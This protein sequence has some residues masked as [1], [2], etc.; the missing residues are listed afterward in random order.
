VEEGRPRVIPVHGLG[1]N[2]GWSVA[3][4]VVVVMKWI[5]VRVGVGR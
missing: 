1:L 5:E 3:R 2:G 4:L